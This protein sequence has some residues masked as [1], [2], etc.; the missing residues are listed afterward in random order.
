LIE[1]TEP[2]KILHLISQHPESTGSGFYVQNIISQAAAAGHQNF[3]IAGITGSQIPHI[4]GIDR[5]CCRFVRFEN[6]DLNFTIPGMSNVMPYSSSRF[7]ALNARQLT[8]YERVFAETIRQAAQDFSP[9]IL[10]THHLWLASSVARTVLPDL[11]MVTSCHSTD[12][13]QFVQCPHLRERVRPSCL[14]IDRVLALSRDQSK[15]IQ[16]IHGITAA[17]I[18]IVGGGYDQELFIPSVK[19]QAP[20]IRLL[21]AGKLSLAK[22][23]DWLLQTFAG[24]HDPRLHLHIAG[25]GSGEEARQCLNLAEKEGS[26]VTVHG[27]INQQELARLMGSCHIFVLPSFYEG[28]PLVL[29]EAVASGCRIIAT[30][31]PGCQELLAGAG[32]DLAAFVNLPVL[33][34]IDRPDPKDLGILQTHLAAAVTGMADRVRIAPSPPLA[35]ASRIT[36]VSSWR[37]VFER[38]L[39]SYEK[40]MA[41]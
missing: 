16:E 12:L 17:R 15:K 10:H 22:G 35:E 26:R 4:P 24:L 41:G 7:D 34:T 29:L 28:L 21:Y 31:L 40:A 18:D 9:D 30:D 3:L 39:V 19:A 11:P 27:G 1:A 20:P 5:D 33:S 36:S 2:L 13:R 23:V 37:A 14:K 8:A 6:G 32:P 38:I 25:S